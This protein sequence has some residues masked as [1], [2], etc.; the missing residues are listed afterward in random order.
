MDKSE[1][2]NQQKF[3]TQKTHVTQIADLDT[4]SLKIVDKKQIEKIPLFNQ[5]LKER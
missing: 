1:I 5:D 3:T 4:K 2:L